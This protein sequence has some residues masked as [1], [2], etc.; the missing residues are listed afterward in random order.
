MKTPLL[1]GLA[2]TLVVVNVLLVMTKGAG[3]LQGATLLGFIVGQ[4]ILFPLIIVAIAAVWKNNR[5]VVRSL[6]VFSIVSVLL[7]IS[8]AVQVIG[9]LSDPPKEVTGK[10]GHVKIAVPSSWETFPGM[11]PSEA[12]HMV[13]QSGNENFAVIPEERSAETSTAQQIAKRA[14]DRIAASPNLKGTRGPLA[15]V[16]DSLPCAQ[17][18]MDLEISGIPVTM[19]YSVVEGKKSF[20]HLLATTGTGL[21]SANRGTFSNILASFEELP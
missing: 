11:G 19:Q 16:V 5:T 1:W 4:V 18:E 7:T 14:A 20:Y 10:F 8:L 17:Y 6:S 2:A 12:I 15:C 21:F 9:V 3:G 13:S